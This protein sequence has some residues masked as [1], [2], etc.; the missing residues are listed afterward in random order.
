MADLTIREII[1]SIVNGQ[2]RVPAF[3]RG[4]VWDA[5]RVAYLMDSIFKGYPIG[6]ILFW[7]TREKLK[8]ERKLAEFVLPDADPAYPI[9]YILD[10]QQRITSLFGVF[11][12]EIKS[13]GEEDWTHIYF[14]YR[15]DPNAQDSQFVAIPENENVDPERHFLL[16]S[17]FDTVAYRKATKDFDNDLA[18]KID[19][20]QS[21]FKEF[22]IPIQTISTDDRTTVAIVFERVNQRGVELNTLQLL[23]AWAWSEEFDLQRQFEDLGNELEPFG[24]EDVGQDTNLVLRC[25]A[26]VLSGN[27]STNTLINLNGAVVRERFGEVVNGIKGAIDFLRDNLQVSA[28]KNLPYPALL[29]PL[30]VFFAVPGARQFRYTQEQ[31]Q[32]I[33]NWFWRTCFSRRYNSQPVKS[34]QA[35]VLEIN[36]LRNKETSSLSTIPTSVTPEFFKDNTFRVDSVGTKTFVLMLAQKHPLSFLNGGAISLRE[37]LKEYNRNQF[38]HLYPRAHLKGTKVEYDISCLANFC[39]MSQ[40]DNNAI[41]AQAPSE[42]RKLMTG[43]VTDILS[44]AI[45]PETLFADDFKSFVDE[46]A[47]MLATEAGRLVQQ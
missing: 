9:D 18:E 45:C 26:A 27:A 33:L 13:E 23:S 41:S 8:F 34:I 7:R 17:F 3:Q 6:S 25:C 42:Y 39:F 43:D 30:S 28:L 40:S 35:D 21:T 12:T 15:A 36:K 10:G 32:V 22:R 4:F 20:V 16:R 19:R 46:R 38:H 11:Q 37:V 44:R 14:D 5:N 24:F 47:V 1:N 29:V 31:R 2:I